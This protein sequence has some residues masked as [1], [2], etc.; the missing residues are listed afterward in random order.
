MQEQ[1]IGALNGT[2]LAM[3]FGQLEA[4]AQ[5]LNMSIQDA[6]NLTERL[7]FIESSR[8]QFDAFDGFPASVQ[9]N[10]E[11]Q[12]VFGY[13]DSL[14]PSTHV[15]FD[16]FSFNEVGEDGFWLFPSS[17]F[18]PN[19]PFAAR[20]EARSAPWGISGGFL[21]GEIY[22]HSG[23]VASRRYVSV[24][25]RVPSPGMVIVEARFT[26][27]V[28][29]GN[30]VRECG[31]YR[32]FSGQSV[33]VFDAA[34]LPAQNPFVVERENLLVEEGTLVFIACE[35]ENLAGGTGIRASFLLTFSKNQ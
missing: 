13:G 10:E 8:V 11:G 9:A 32:K 17:G 15:P 1:I 6:G 12:L 22:L 19:G 29:S 35:D 21:D 31:V 18:S 7:A 27:P 3:Q 28:G 30:N 16:A 26:V 4:S 5:A 34:L 2:A 20:N 14:D 33:T 23:S 24:V 25:F